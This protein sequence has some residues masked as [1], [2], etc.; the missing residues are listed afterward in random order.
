MSNWKVSKQKIALF[1]HHNA[2]KLELARIGSYQCVI[3]KGLYKDGDEVIFAPEK[4]VLTGKIREEY[5]NYLAGINHDR[6]KS[7]SLRGEYSCGI[8]IPQ[9]L[10]GELDLATIEIDQDISDK[11]GI[12]QYVPQIPQELTGVMEPITM[13]SRYGKHDCEQFGVY[14]NEFTDGERIIVTEKLHGSQAVYFLDLPSGETFVTSKNQ[15]NNGLQIIESDSNSYWKAAKS[16]DLWNVISR[17]IPESINEF[18]LH[19]VQAFGELLPI[20]KGYS[21]GQ[22]EMTVKLFDLRINGISVPYDQLSDEIK[23]IWVP[24]IYDGPLDKSTIRKLSEGM[25]TVSG[26]A[27]HIKEGVVVAPYI[28]RKAVDGT[29]LR[30]KILNPKYKEVGEE[31][32]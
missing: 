19:T 15:L 10:L 5:A 20:Q 30:L 22:T 24:V 4:S 27:L 17:E 2:E 26:K 1:E 7:V 9:E 25:E 13:S 18:D 31:I 23:K 29:R 3:Q 21:Y 11:L 28:D 8:I 14:A 12:S 16:L 32:N 6:V